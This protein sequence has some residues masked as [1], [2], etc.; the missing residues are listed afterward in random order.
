MIP[1]ILS[2]L[3]HIFLPVKNIFFMFCNFK[4]FCMTLYRQT[5]PEKFQILIV[6][7]ISGK[8]KIYLYFSIIV[9]LIFKTVPETYFVLCDC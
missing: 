6:S 2:N 1:K 5:S 9:S 7:L 8:Y 3:S 4:A